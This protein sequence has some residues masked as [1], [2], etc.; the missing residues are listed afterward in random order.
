MEKGFFE[1]KGVE[2]PYMSTT[3]SVDG[4]EEEFILATDALWSV[5]ESDWEEW[6]EDALRLDNEIFYYLS[7]EEF[8]SINSEEELN[9]W[10]LNFLNEN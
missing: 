4:V 1:Y 6:D 10:V 2:Y 7:D 5:M 9:N 8:S 3:L